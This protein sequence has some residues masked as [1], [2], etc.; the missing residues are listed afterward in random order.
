[1]VVREERLR[2]HWKSEQLEKGGEAGRNRNSS[3]GGKKNMI[4][5]RGQHESAR[6]GT[7]DTMTFQVC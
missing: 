7:T 2:K 3:R 6:I 1:M 5:S 4:R